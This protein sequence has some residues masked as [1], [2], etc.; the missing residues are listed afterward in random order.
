MKIE[1]EI[2]K[3][4]YNNLIEYCVNEKLDTKEYITSCIIHQLNSDIYGDMNDNF[5]KEDD[6]RCNTYILVKKQ[7]QNTIIE[8]NRIIRK[9]KSK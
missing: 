7:E 2:P 4:V 8:G 9:I 6:I 1:V 5:N 3:R